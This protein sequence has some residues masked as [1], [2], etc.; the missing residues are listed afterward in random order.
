[1]ED[2]K[3]AKFF[4]NWIDVRRIWE[5]QCLRKHQSGDSGSTNGNDWIVDIL[6]LIYAA[7]LT[8]DGSRK[9]LAIIEINAVKQNSGV[10]F[11]V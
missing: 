1:M 7:K 11:S 10:P 8:S 4:T 3:S 2:H 5:H 6:D 9:G